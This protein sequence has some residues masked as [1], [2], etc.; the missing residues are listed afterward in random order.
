MSDSDHNGQYA[1]KQL[2]QVAR[3]DFSHAYI[4][5][6]IRAMHSWIQRENNDLLP[7]D[8][9]RKHIPMRGQHY[10]GLQQIE[11]QK[12]IGSV[13]RFN[14]FDRAF[15]PRQT[16][17]RGRWESIDRAYFQDVILPP[18]DVYKVGDVYFVKDGNHR[19]SVARERGQAYMDAYVIEVDIPGTLDEN[20]SLDNLIMVQEYAEFLNLTRLD[21]FY[22]DQDFHFSIPG[23]YGKILQHIS[24]HQWFMGEAQKHPI[25]YFDAVKGW[26]KD[27]Y[28]PLVKIIRKHKIL[29]QFPGRTETDLYLWIIEHRWFLGEELKRPVS[30]EAA[31]LNFAQKF[32][33]KPFEQI[34][35]AFAKFFER[36]KKTAK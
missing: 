4:K 2:F 36:F 7:Y 1:G 13:S 5:G 24:V 21:Q 27:L 22:P 16:H 34:K 9:V 30:L 19:V 23:Q 35:E 31:A 11:T 33:Q 10:I 15:L 3:D 14:D 29:D 6:F 25:E 17:T 8:E 28:H 32:K 18:I 26:Y 20:T 12:I